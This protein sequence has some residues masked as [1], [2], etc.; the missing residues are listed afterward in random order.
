LIDLDGFKQVND[1]YGHASG[2]LVLQEVG[3]RLLALAEPGIFF[4]RLGG[5]EFGVLAQHKLANETLVELGDASAKRSAS[6]IGWPAMS[7]N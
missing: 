6:P 3:E 7:P 5:D 2:D 1:I 4:A